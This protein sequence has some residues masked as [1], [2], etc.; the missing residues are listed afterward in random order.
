LIACR[1]SLF[2][3]HGTEPITALSAGL[4]TVIVFWVDSHRP[5]I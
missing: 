2:P 5:S 1:V 4:L 3:K